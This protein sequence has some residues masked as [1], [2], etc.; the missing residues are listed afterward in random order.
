MLAWLTTWGD[1]QICIGPSWCQCRSLSVAPVNPD[2]FYLSSMGPLGYSP[3]Q[4][5]VKHVLLLL[6]LF[7]P[8]A[9]CKVVVMSMRVCLSVCLSVRSQPHGRTSPN[10]FA[11]R[12]WPRLGHLLTVLRYVIYF[13]FR[14][15]RYVLHSGPVARHV[16]SWAAIEYG[17]LTAEIPITFFSTIRT[18]KYLSWVAHRSKICYLRLSCL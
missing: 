4:R 15:W 8:L 14:R 7:P 1:V 3:G 10:F 13:R 18:S 2:W 9:G 12:L 6:L 11:C 17:K 16:Y 5:A